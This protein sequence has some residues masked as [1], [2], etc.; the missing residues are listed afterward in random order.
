MKH[1]LVLGMIAAAGL[2]ASTYYVTVAGLGGEPEYEQRF[3]GWA[4]DID[5]ALKSA[6]DAKAETLFGEAATRRVVRSPG[7]RR[8]GGSGHLP[9]LTEWQTPGRCQDRSPPARENAPPESAGRH[10]QLEAK[11]AAQTG[12]AENSH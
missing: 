7:V 5:K 4:K 1:A 6:P 3:S 8:S 10:H 11:G 12:G 2:D 9:T